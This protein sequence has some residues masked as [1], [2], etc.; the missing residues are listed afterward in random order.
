MGGKFKGKN[1]VLMTLDSKVIFAVGN[2]TIK[3][4]KMPIFCIRTG[5]DM[6]DKVIK[7]G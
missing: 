1:L 6:L 7:P 3:K 4:K 2:M 5:T